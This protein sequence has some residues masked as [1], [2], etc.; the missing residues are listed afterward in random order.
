ML[1]FSERILSPTT[2]QYLRQRIVG[3]ALLPYIYIIILYFFSIS[4]SILL[5]QKSVGIGCQY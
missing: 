2:L 4:M 1:L 5:N 3:Y